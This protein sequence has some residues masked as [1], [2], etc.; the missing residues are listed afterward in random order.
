MKRAKKPEPVLIAADG[1]EIRRRYE[2]S[3]WYDRRLKDPSPWH[4]GFPKEEDGSIKTASHLVMSGKAA[5]VQCFDRVRGR[6]EWTVDR[7]DR[8]PR[9]HLYDPIISHGEPAFEN[10]PARRKER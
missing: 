10:K 2:T 6:V 7:G 8:V 3:I 9:T 1:R 5:R 4:R